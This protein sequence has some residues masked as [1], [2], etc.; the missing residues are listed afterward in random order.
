MTRKAFLISC[1]IVVCCIAAFTPQPISSPETSSLPLL[2]TLEET[3]TPSPT[4]STQIEIKPVSSSPDGVQEYTISM[5]I[6]T[7]SPQVF[8]PVPKLWDGVGTREVNVL[9]IS[10]EPSDIYPDENGN[11]ILYWTRNSYK[12]QVFSIVFRIRLSPIDQQLDPALD[13][14]EPV[15]DLEDQ[16]IAF[17]LK[18]EPWL[19]IYQARIIN[20]A[21]DIAGEETNPVVLAQLMMEWIDTH[22]KSTDVQQD[23]LQTL[24]T[25]EGD[26]VSKANLFAALMRARGVPARNVSG[27]TSDLENK[28]EQLISGSW[29][30]GDLYPRV[31]SEI[32]L[33]GYGWYQLD[34][35]TG[36]MGSFETLRL[37]LTKG[38]RIELNHGDPTPETWFHLPRSIFEELRKANTWVLVTTDEWLGDHR[39][40]IMPRPVPSEIP[41]YHPYGIL[42]G[43][44]V[45][46][47]YSGFHPGYAYGF[48]TCEEVKT[49]IYGQIGGE[50]MGTA[51]D[52][53][54]DI[55]GKE[56]FVKVYFGNFLLSD[57]EEAELYGL[58]AHVVPKVEIGDI[59]RL[60]KAL[61]AFST[62][63]RYNYTPELL[64]T[65]LKMGESGI[66]EEINPLLVGLEPY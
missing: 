64:F 42:T 66:L 51:V 8:M 22:I 28:P 13:F 43:A 14:S 15:Y 57:G 37:I 3:P 29:L 18:A 53:K 23:A 59:L 62:C 65:I 10:P 31:W 20:R 48:N 35:C 27:Y 25:R 33:P 5:R 21:A 17:N 58:Y 60:D 12:R 6:S 40:L 47:G 41:L 4:E 38:S 63:K 7:T 34:V 32:Y 11:E 56:G 36:E 49:L 50:V 19:Q 61:A 26:C 9:E 24:Q 44:N 16:E 46:P 1:V 52:M 39:S 45:N 2:P 30:A 55:G 54:R